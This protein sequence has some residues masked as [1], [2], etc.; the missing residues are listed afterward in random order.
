MEERERSRSWLEVREMD[1]DGL[2]VE[3]EGGAKKKRE[4]NVSRVEWHGYS[5]SA[6]DHFSKPLISNTVKT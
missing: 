2:K 3:R 5:A 4:K 6:C 1:V